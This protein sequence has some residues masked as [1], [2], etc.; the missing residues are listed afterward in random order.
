MRLAFGDI[1]DG[2][3]MLL[4]HGFPATRRLWENV[5]PHLSGIR[6]IAVDMLGYGDSPDAPDVGMAAQAKALLSFLDELGLERIHLAAHDVG[7]AAAQI[8]T[9][10]APERIRSLTLIDG[11]YESEWAMDAVESIRAWDVTQA[12]RLQPLLSRRLKSIRPSLESFAGEHGGRRLIHAARC[13][14]PSDTVGLTARVRTTRVPVRVIWGAEDTYLPA[15]RVGRPLAAALGTEL[16]VV[17]GGHFL[18]IDNGPVVAQLL[19]AQVS[20]SPRKWS[21]SW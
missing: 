6:A 10:H 17:P 12:A 2:A 15:D 9:A 21:N 13:L 7:T 8:L 1:G 16:I 14:E 19:T 11:V 20:G 18:P 4:V 5:I 3:P